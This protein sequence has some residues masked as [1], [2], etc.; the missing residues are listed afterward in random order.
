VGTMNRGGDHGIFR[1]SNDFCSYFTT[2]FPSPP[3][4]TS[5]LRPEALRS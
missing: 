3:L 5:L 2:P 4:P 1:L